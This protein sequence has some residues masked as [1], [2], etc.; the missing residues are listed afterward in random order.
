M[1]V[2]HERTR[3]LRETGRIRTVGII[4]EQHPG[5]ARLFMQWKGMDWPILVDSLDLLDVSVVPIT[6]LIYN[7]TLPASQ[8]CFQH[9][10]IPDSV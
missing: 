8:C 2:W 9:N 7:T 3:E 6:V 5:R 1:P 4:Q 10:L